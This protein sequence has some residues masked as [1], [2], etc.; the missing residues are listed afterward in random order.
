MTAV[1]PASA[2]DELDR[3]TESLDRLRARIDA[4]TDL[5]AVARHYLRQR[6]KRETMFKTELFADPAWDL[7]LDL[8]VQTHIGRQTSVSSA[9]LAAGVAPTTALRYVVKLEAAGLIRRVPDPGDR[10]R[11][12]LELLSP[13]ERAIRDWIEKT[14][15]AGI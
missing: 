5:V 12:F 11:Y 9:C 10:R 4:R 15:P 3:L 2:L 14:W 6:R 8:L 13:A 7:L 1:H